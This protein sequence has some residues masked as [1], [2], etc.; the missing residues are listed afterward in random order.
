MIDQNGSNTCWRS[1]KAMH[2][3]YLA[4]PR[5]DEG[6]SAAD[7]V[8]SYREEQRIR[9]SFFQLANAL[10]RAKPKSE[11]ELTAQLKELDEKIKEVESDVKRGMLIR[12]LSQL[13]QPA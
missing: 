7:L 12:H 5:Y 9:R 2:E 4:Q 1:L 3:H 8:R 11:I 10:P 6:K 13:P